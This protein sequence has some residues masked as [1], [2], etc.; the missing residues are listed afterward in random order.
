LHCRNTLV[1]QA[2]KFCKKRN[3]H[4]KK[5][6]LQTKITEVEVLQHF[7]SLIAFITSAM[8]FTYEKLETKEDSFV[9]EGTLYLS[10]II[11]SAIQT[12][13]TAVV[14]LSGGSTPGI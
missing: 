11:K 7:K 4:N 5:E 13:G 1:Q 12:R 8:A 9:K 3:A 6:S 14:G 2:E 10:N